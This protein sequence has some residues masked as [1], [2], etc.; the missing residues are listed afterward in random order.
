MARAPKTESAHAEIS[1]DDERSK[2]K[3]EQVTATWKNFWDEQQR[4]EA[5]KRTKKV[6]RVRKVMIAVF[7]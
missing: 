4:V 3:K 7:H 1:H 2:E 6:E 5:D